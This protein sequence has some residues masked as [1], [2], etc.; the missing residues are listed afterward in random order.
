MELTDLT[1]S[2]SALARIYERHY[3]K[4]GE[5]APRLYVTKLQ[6]G[7]IIAEIAPF[8]ALMAQTLT[9]LDYAMVVADFSE[10]ISRVIRAF[11]NNGEKPDVQ[12]RDEARDFGLFLKPLKGRN[13]AK[14]GIT[15]ASFEKRTGEDYIK[16]EYK[17]EDREIN[18]AAVNIEEALKPQSQI[19]EAHPE[20]IRPEVALVIKRAEDGPGKETGR[21]GD[22][23]IVDEV[24]DKALPVYFRKSAQDIKQKMM[25]G[26]KNPLTHTFIV[27][28]SVQFDESENPSGYI[29]T[30]V[31]DAWERSDE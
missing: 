12:N 28:V 30:D 31:H 3:R 22:R 7:S 14:L 2:F 21:T 29:V 13:G 17:F 4:N 16:A 10:R 11:S 6:T 9:A 26:D 27:D 18:L 24:S 20:R 15:H 5:E 23:G 1:D 8:T 19:K 25:K